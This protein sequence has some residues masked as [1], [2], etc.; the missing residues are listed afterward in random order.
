VRE[1][2]NNLELK[3][4]FGWGVKDEKGE[5][6]SCTSECRAGLPGSGEGQFTSPTGV[7]LDEKGILWITDS[8]NARVEEFTPTGEYITQF[9]SGQFALTHGESRSAEDLHTSPTARTI[10]WS[11]GK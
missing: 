10:E 3:L 4:G 1:F 7:A 6:E 8:G 11:G 2:S 5:L 9:G